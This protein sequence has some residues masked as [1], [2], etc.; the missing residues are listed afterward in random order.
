[1]G[2]VDGPGAP[3]LVAGVGSVSKA[4][5][6]SSGLASPASAISAGPASMGLL[7]RSTIGLGSQLSSP[8]AQ[9]SYLL[10]RINS[11][12]IVTTRGD[13]Y[14]GFFNKKSD[15]A[16]KPPAFFRGSSPGGGGF[17]AGAGVNMSANSL[18]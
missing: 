8:Q 9:E 2:V 1:M 17:W 12:D 6:V 7:K 4:L 10:N 18:W 5:G 14:L 15:A 11:F 13:D 16:A 3:G